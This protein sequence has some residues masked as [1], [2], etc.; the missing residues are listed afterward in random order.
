MEALD[1]MA[2]NLANVNTAGYKEQKAFFSVLRDT[3]NSSSEN[4]LNPLFP[5]RTVLARA[6]MNLSD[7]ILRTTQRDLDVALVGDGFM[8]VSTPRG[9][10]YTRNGSMSINAKGELAT[11]DGMPILGENGSPIA[12]TSGKV[13][14]TE[15]GEVYLNGTRVDRI[16][17]TTFD[18]PSQLLMEGNS[19]LA[20]GNSEMK[21]K[22]G[23]TTMRQG[24]LEQSNVNAVTSVVE[25]VQ[26]MRRFESIQKG[27]NL[28]LNDL[29][30][31]SIEKL[32]R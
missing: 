31:K 24:F 1:I 20:P 13:N 23:N 16:K 7:G 14:I 12:L 17:I 4:D 19:L 15:Q 32:G 5:E 30:S 11:A 25:M 6:T 3:M 22:P 29:D 27:V 28:V 21:T 9:V 2:N 8:A 10:R 18:N 26:I